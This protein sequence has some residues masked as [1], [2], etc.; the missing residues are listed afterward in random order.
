MVA[1]LNYT[2]TVTPYGA[3]GTPLHVTLA[4]LSPTV[5]SVKAKLHLMLRPYY[6]LTL[7]LPLNL[8]SPMTS[9]LNHDSH[10]GRI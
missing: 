5:A 8:K 3:G 1:H 7:T 9:K 2:D 10:V 4:P 6:I